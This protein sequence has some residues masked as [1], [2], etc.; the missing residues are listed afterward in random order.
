MGAPHDTPVN[1]FWRFVSK[2]DGCWLWTGNLDRKGY[3]RFYDGIR[4]VAAHRFS[5]ALHHGPFDLS[6]VVRHHCDNPRC[7]N[8]QHLAV[9]T[10]AEN[11][12][13]MFQRGRQRAESTKARGSQIANSSINEETAARIHQE[14][15]NAPK[16]R[17]GRLR[18]G[19][20]AELSSRTGVSRYIISRI[21][22]GAWRHAAGGF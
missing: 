12:K 2:N 14:I 6:L 18:R 4:S 3:G 9:G 5:F 16:S 8:P 13:D 22:H 11:V 21:A 10:Q 17:T 7:V 19:S 20:L 15:I 1:R